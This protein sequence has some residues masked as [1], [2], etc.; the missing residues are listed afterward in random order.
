[1]K[2]QKNFNVANKLKSIREER[3]LSIRSLC[4]LS[5]LAVNTLSLIENGKTSP[6]VN[7]LYKL[8]Y[9]LNIPITSFFDSGDIHKEIHYSRA[10]E[11]NRIATDTSDIT[12]ITSS[13]SASNQITAYS[14]IIHPG[15]ISGA[16]PFMHE[17]YEFILCLE[18]RI[19]FIVKNDAFIL[20]GGDS[21]LFNG[22]LP[23]RWLNEFP[24]SAKMLAIF[25][26][27]FLKVKS[28]TDHF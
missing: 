11:Q 1:M 21:L 7:T 13:F 17:E 12:E 10:D 5:G 6:S 4:S 8:A 22:S 26:P 24:E 28:I 9:A 23:H 25:F 18:G 2:K 15:T 20:E 3:D 16:Q 19:R 14:V 27:S